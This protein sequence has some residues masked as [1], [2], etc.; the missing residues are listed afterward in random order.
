MQRP[1]VG[2][3][4]RPEN[5]PCP[6]GIYRV[7]GTGDEVTL[8]RVADAT[9]RRTHTGE[10]IAVAV[11][12]LDG[13]DR[14]PNPDG[15]RPPLATLASTLRMGY[16]SARAFVGELAANPLAATLAGA[17]LG[18]GLFGE[19]VLPVSDLGH[20]VLI[21]VGSLSLAYAG[22]GRL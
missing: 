9:G 12:E 17:L 20:G 19:G 10:V 5:A 6:D 7:V 13:F 3:H 21:L 4:L 15:D 11:A 2:D 14:A 16:W 22:S 1:A 8:L 18:A